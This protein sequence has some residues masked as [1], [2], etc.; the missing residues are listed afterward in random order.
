TDEASRYKLDGFDLLNYVPHGRHGRATYVRANIMDAI[1]LESTNFYDVIQVGGYQIANVYKPPSMSWNEQVLPI[2]PHPAVYVGDFNR[3]HTDWGYT[4]VDADSE[5]LV[6]WASKND[7]VLIHDAKQRGTFHSARW[8]R[9][10]SPDLCWVSTL[11]RLP[12][13]VTCLVLDNFPHSQHR[14]SFIHIGLQLPIVRSSNKLQWNFRKVNWEKYSGTLEQSIIVIPS[15]NIPI[16]KAYSNL[17]SSW[18]GYPRGYHLVYIPCLNAECEA[19][20]KQYKLSRDPDLADHVIESL[21]ERWEEAME[22]LDFTRSSRKSW[23]LIQPPAQSHSVV[24]PNQLV[25][26]MLKV[27]KFV[28]EKEIRQQVRGEWRKYRRNNNTQHSPEP[29]TVSELDEILRRVKPGTAAGYDNILPEL[30]EHLGNRA[31]KWLAQFFTRVAR[32]ESFQ[33]FG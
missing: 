21:D 14:P 12:L 22:S 4:E 17:Q 6:D 10:Y 29:F 2:L 18:Y 15:R 27:A 31:R 25:S 20:L 7:I 5:L 26:H 11:D 19:L 16:D 1:S 13:P 30:L 9:D 28:V 24:T 33:D 3:H 32:E 8:S 23:N